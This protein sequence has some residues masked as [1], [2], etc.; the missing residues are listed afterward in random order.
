MNR[1][2][3]LENADRELNE[4]SARLESVKYNIRSLEN[5]MALLNS[6][7]IQFSQQIAV[8]K[9]P[10]VITSILEYKKIR[11]DLTIVNIRLHMLRIDFNNQH[12]AL[13]QIEKILFEAKERYAILLRNQYGRVIKGNF[14]GKK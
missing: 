4:L 11:D 14:G 13:L 6:I 10:D 7:R 8:H 9:S 5:N 12:V 2:L 1:L 3:D